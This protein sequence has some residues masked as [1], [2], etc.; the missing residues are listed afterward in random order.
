MCPGY[1]VVAT[2]F[3]PQDGFLICSE[4]EGILYW[5]LKGAMSV[6]KLRDAVVV[7]D[8]KERAFSI[9]YNWV[10]DCQG[11]VSYIQQPEKVPPR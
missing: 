11:K 7:L 9:V 6:L 4:L 10:K 3:V 5:H 2:T 8:L 1:R